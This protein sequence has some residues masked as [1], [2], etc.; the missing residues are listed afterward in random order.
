M[1]W[2]YVLSIQAQRINS[3]HTGPCTWWFQGH[4]RLLQSLPL[5]WL[6]IL[7]RVH[8]FSTRPAELRRPGGSSNCYYS[9]GLVVSWREKKG[10]RTCHAPRWISL[11]RS[12]ASDIKFSNTYPLSNPGIV[13]RLGT[14]SISA[15]MTGHDE[16]C[17]RCRRCRLRSARP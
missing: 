16:W 12:S 1:F 14:S 13:Q 2:W 9:L 10:T 17:Q 8:P 11:A 6:I 4:M 5:G 7:S 15:A 3:H